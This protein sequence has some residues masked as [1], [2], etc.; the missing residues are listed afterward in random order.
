MT[1]QEGAAV[2]VIVAGL[3][4]GAFLVAQRPSF[5][6]EF[7]ARLL[8]RLWPFI[9]AMVMKRMSAEEE[10][11]WRAEQQAG[12]GD[13]WMRQRLRRGKPGRER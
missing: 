3:G 1:W 13:E 8:G 5:W 2:V 4:A 9:A 11:E 7:G 6:V 10:A 12:R